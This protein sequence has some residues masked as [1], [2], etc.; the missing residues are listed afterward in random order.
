[1]AVADY[2]TTIMV[3]SLIL[4]IA[5]MALK[6]VR[7]C[8]RLIAMCLG[9]GMLAIAVLVPAVYEAS[10]LL[11]PQRDLGKFIP[12]NVTPAV[13]FNTALFVCVVYAML[14]TH[15]FITTV[16][17]PILKR[18]PILLVPKGKERAYD[19]RDRKASLAA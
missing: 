2:V 18:G 17:V 5:Q 8:Y 10:R 9:C 13:I 3:G 15:I 14:S 6:V 16:V 7:P 1:M 11:S 12:L 19:L 4:K